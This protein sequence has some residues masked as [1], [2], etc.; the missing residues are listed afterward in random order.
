MIDG[1]VIFREI[2]SEECHWTL[3]LTSQHWFRYWLGAARQKAITWANVDLDLCHQMVSLGHCELT[4]L[5]LGW[6]RKI[7]HV[8]AVW[9]ISIT[10][11]LTTFPKPFLFVFGFKFHWRL[12]QQVQLT[13]SHQLL[14]WWLWVNR[15][16]THYLNQYWQRSLTHMAFPGWPHWA[17][18]S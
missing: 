2:P 9:D 15:Q 5:L 6:H 4:R 12:F 8:W 14:R 7:T 13:R 10:H 1:W 18:M 11:P 17:A 16:Q 3:L